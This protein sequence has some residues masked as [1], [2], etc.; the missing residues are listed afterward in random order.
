MDMAT[1]PT[2]TQAPKETDATLPASAEA[3]LAATSAV[4]G[5]IPLP[6]NT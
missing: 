5:L 4:P 3:L 2:P 1:E 6:S